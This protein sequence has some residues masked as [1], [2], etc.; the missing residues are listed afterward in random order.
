MRNRFNNITSKEWLPFQKS[1]FIDQGDEETYRSNLRFFLR[2]DDSLP[3]NIFYFGD[4]QGEKTIKKVAKSLNIKVFSPKS[5][6]KI[7][8]LQLILI[9]IRRQEE[10]LSLSAY[11]KLKKEV[12]EWAQTLYPY[13]IH[14]RFLSIMHQNT[15]HRGHYLPFAWDMSKMLATG[16]S[17]RDEK[18]GCYENPHASAKK[19]APFTQATYYF[20]YFRKDEHSPGEFS[21]PDINFFQ[22]IKLEK[23]QFKTEVPN[24]KIFRPKR[25]NKNEI[26]HPAKFP[27]EVA[28]FFIERFTRPKANV[29]D[30]MSGTG[31]TQLAALQTNRNGYGTELSAFF[32][33]IAHTRITTLVETLTQK[34][35]HK[36]LL[37]DARRI[38]KR[39]FPPID[40]LFTSPP[41]WDMLNMKGAE[42]QATRKAKGLQLN[43]SDDTHDLGNISEYDEFVDELCN[44]YFKL[45]QKMSPGAYLTIIVKNIKK[46]GK[47]YPLA[48][49][50]AWKLQEH[51]TLLPEFFWLQ[52]DLRLAPYG[53]GYTFVSNTFHQYCLTFRK[54]TP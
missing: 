11:R 18:I 4:N 9:D 22:K 8:E 15:L 21:M 38:T 12:L 34:P 29:F 20:S 13:L 5:I 46:K 24:W 43:Y 32:I 33:E 49:D 19:Y 51:F 35:K 36:L 48:D 2:L 23:N 54:K 42:N 30:P 1:W 40:Y 17:R 16:L 50:L 39:D 3:Q 37:K 26:L 27:E 28:Q 25:R 10:N 41:Y 52:D 45:A 53:Y 7:P 6:Q 47:S 44:I 31:S 14:R